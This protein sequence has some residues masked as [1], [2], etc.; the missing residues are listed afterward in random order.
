[1]PPTI[2]SSSRKP[3]TSNPAASPA[4]Q[5]PEHD[6]S[7]QRARRDDK[8]PIKRPV[9]RP[10]LPQ[11]IEATAGPEHQR[12]V[13]GQRSARV[14]GER[15]KRDAARPGKPQAQR[16]RGAEAKLHSPYRGGGH[17][18]GHGRKAEQ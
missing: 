16:S 15:Q 4:R 8:T 5:K 6:D 7:E 12:P 1:M 3:C 10:R 14:Q 2:A 18:R 9:V 17:E 13:D 11:A